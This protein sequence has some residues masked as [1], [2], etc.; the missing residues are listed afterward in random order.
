MKKKYRDITVDHVK[1]AW[2]VIDDDGDAIL[3]IWEDKK[4]IHNSYV[5]TDITPKLVA[6][7]I[8]LYKH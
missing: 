3:R 6:D 8:R 7:T 2:N 1:Y 5:S 4:I